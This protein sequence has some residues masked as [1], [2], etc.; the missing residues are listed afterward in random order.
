MAQLC[1][2]SLGWFGTGEQQTPLPEFFFIYTVHR[3]MH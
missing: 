3:Q 1:G 2:H